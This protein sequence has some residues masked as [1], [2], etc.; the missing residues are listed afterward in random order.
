MDKKKLEELKALAEKAMP[1]PWRSVG[2]AICIRSANVSPRGRELWIGDAGHATAAF[3]AAANPT[4]VLEMIEQNEELREA[5][6]ALRSVCFDWR[7]TLDEFERL[8]EL[9]YQEFRRLR[10]G[11]DDP[12]RDSNEPENIKQY[13]E[14]A[15]KRNE[16]AID[17]ADAALAKAEGD[18]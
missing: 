17:R 4:T 18:A 12:F 9:Y 1:G 6:K 14:W 3:I 16:D 13:D 2:G 7:K 15:R 11:K 10:P 8:G 5:L